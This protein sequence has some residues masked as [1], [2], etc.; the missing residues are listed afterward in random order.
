MT[1]DRPVPVVPDFG[2]ASG[3]ATPLILTPT[4]ALAFALGYACAR[5]QSANHFGPFCALIEEMSRRETGETPTDAQLG[6]WSPASEMGR[7]LSLLPP[8]LSRAI[9]TLYQAQRGQRWH[10]TGQYRQGSGNSG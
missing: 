8:D 5:P 6:Q 10:R 3:P 1:D 7:L 4:A 2:A 9:V